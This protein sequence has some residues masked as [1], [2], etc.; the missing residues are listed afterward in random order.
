MLPGLEFPKTNSWFS[1]NIILLYH[2]HKILEKMLS[3]GLK[4]K[5]CFS[6][7]PAANFVKTDVFDTL[8]WKP[9]KEIFSMPSFST[10]GIGLNGH[11][12][13]TFSKRVGFRKVEIQKN[14][15]NCPKMGWNGS[16]KMIGGSREVRKGQNCAANPLEGLP[17]LKTLLKNSKKVKNLENPENQGFPYFSYFPV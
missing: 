12:G 17:D 11:M 5:T 7:K 10:G 8:V 6:W 15:E 2:K 3:D 4:W 16:R 9:H 14:V 13:A 1:K